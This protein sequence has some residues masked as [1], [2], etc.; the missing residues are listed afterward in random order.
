LNVLDPDHS[1][2]LHRL[3]RQHT[4]VTDE[5]IYLK[6]LSKLGRDLSKTII[7]DNIRE[8]FERQDQNGIEIKTWIGDP[9]DRELDVLAGFLRGVVEA[10]VKDVRPIVKMFRQQ[11]EVGIAR[12]EEAAS[13]AANHV[14]HK[15]PIKS[16]IPKGYYTS[17]E[18]V[19]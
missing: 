7:V 10:G 16:G 8:N 11:Y 13:Y 19:N 2:I 9:H 4:F 5:G 18:N 3:Y 12:R 1:L 6:D 15:S 14:H 17:S